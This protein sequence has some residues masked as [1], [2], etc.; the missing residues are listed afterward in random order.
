LDYFVTEEQKMIRDLAR[1]V[2]RE[3]V[4]PVRAELDEKEEFPW[5]IMRVCANAGLF[6]VCVPEEYGGFGGGVFENCL[7]VEEMTRGCLGVAVSYAGSSLGAY[8]I[9]VY[10][11]EEQ[12]R[13]YLPD[14][15]SGKRLAAFGLTEANAG[16]DA[17]AIQTTAVL[18]GSEYVINGTKQWVTQ[19]PLADVAT[20][21]ATTDPSKGLKSL[22]FFMTERKTEVRDGFVPGQSLHKVGGRCAMTGELVFDNVFVPDE[23]FLGEELDKGMQYASEI[24]NEVRVMTGVSAL[25][26]AKCALEDAR[27]YANNRIAFGNPIGTYQLIREKFARCWAW[28]EAAR[29]QLYK[30]AW[31]IENPDS[32]GVSF[33][34]LVELCMAAKFHATEM[35]VTTVEEAMRIYG[36]NAFCTEYPAQRYWKN[37][38]YALYGGGTHEVLEDYLG[39]MYLRK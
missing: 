33:R 36:G 3:K 9:L 35:C 8:P 11:N 16:S 27:E 7:A 37:A 15:A 29:T 24:L 32:S 14:I 13:K 38:M 25:A 1:K 28:Y 19:G 21:L 39:R 30:C 20:V 18:D 23:N 34:E 17:G 2:A 10:G 6:G 5:E 12:K 4:I 31:M 26:I 22:N